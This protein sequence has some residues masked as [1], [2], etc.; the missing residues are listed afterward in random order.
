[1]IE[2][3][4]AIIAET[5]ASYVEA[6]RSLT[7]Q[8]KA[9]FE[10]ADWLGVQRD[11]ARRF[12]LYTDA[13]GEGLGRLVPLLGDRERDRPTWTSIRAA[14]ARAIA[15][16]VDVEEAE[17]FFN[18]FSR[19]I[20]HTIGVD[21]AVEFLAPSAP[22]ARGGGE[23]SSVRFERLGSLA[24]L[25]RRILDAYPFAPGWQDASRDAARIARAMEERLEDRNVL[26]IDLARA[27]FFRGKAA[28]LV[29]RAVT[30]RGEVPL[31]IAL[32]NEG[33]G[34][35]VDA[36][37][38]SEDDVSI[39]FSFA[40]SYF[41]VEM[42]EPRETVAFLK[43][44]MPK[45]P[46]AE[47]YNAV[48]CNK[49]GKT[50]LY[51]S[52]L[53]HLETTDD[54][55]EIAPGQRGMV[56]TVFTLPGLDVVFKVIKDRFDYP[57]TV[58]HQE[59]RD[60]Y[61]LVFRHDRAGRLV[62]AQE[63]EHLEF[64]GARFAPAL[65]EELAR[66]A[67]DT[68]RFRGEGVVIGHLYTERR[69]RPLDVYLREAGP[70][71]A[72]QAVI[73]YGQVLRDLAATNIFPGDMLLKNFGVTRHGRLVFYD[74]DELCL[75]S[76]C[77]FR[78]LP[79]ARSDDEELSSEP[80]YYVGERDIFPEEFRAFLGLRRELLEIFLRHH[81]ELLHVDF[82]HRMQDLHRRGEVVDIYPYRPQH[83]LRRGDEEPSR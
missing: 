78:R 22:P 19:K 82:W 31:V 21:P 50:E 63:F 80:W 32:V 55:F 24:F 60:K 44:L 53:R 77:V 67:S 57:K 38:L 34:I 1:M 37:L 45:K 41:F 49:H 3:G 51:R 66:V 25:V 26:A 68:V 47:L 5:Y 27:L 71:A 76:D 40:R 70:D 59:V 61:R 72:T 20:F 39:V 10:A 17:T 79:Q 65:L 42:D 52:I 54:R 15:S 8:A 43:A 11:A 73:E 69:L 74:Y 6:F 35:A 28:Y 30:D 36:L 58:T 29:G 16:R 12:D 56:M 23:G 46:V 18:S 9:R 4:A 48:G 75:L 33:R 13:V 2:D 14:Y 81:E 64:D 83:R 62:D 7:R